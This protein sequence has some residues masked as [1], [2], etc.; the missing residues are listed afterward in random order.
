MSTSQL[1]I[2]SSSACEKG[3]QVDIVLKDGAPWFRACEV[4]RIL[5][6]KNSSDAV[7]KHVQEKY[8][9][10]KDVLGATQGGASKT[11]YPPSESLH[12]PQDLA[13]YIS[14]PGLY[15]LILRSKKKEAEDFQDWVVGTVLP[16]IRAQGSYKSRKPQTKLQI[17]LINEF[18]LHAKVIDFVRRFHPEA[19]IVAGLG[20]NQIN[21]QL[22]IESWQK[23]YTR[24]QCDILFLNK[25]KKWTGLAL[26]LKS[27]IGW[28]VVSPDQQKFL[29]RLQKAGYK[30]LVSNDYDEILVLIQEY[31]KDVRSYC[32]HCDRWVPSKHVHK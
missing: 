13:V 11:L 18:D 20:E 4:T 3:Y 2:Y 17:C 16:E 32:P 26:E 5:G 28:G 12:P 7:K 29:E 6:Y 10:T 22:R 25:H 9:S 23:G 15:S 8:K 14:E 1:A 31:F 30:T 21:E 24:G 27:P 19:N